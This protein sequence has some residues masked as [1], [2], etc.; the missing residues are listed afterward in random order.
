M[1]LSDLPQDIQDELRK[2]R[3]ELYKTW[4]TNNSYHI[5]FTNLEGTRYFKADRIST[6]YSDLN[7]NYMPFGGGSYWK[8]SY[9]KILWN[10]Q[11][12]PMN[13]G[14][15]YFWVAS[16]SKYSTSKNGTEIPDKLAQKSEVIEL[17][18]K[19]GNLIIE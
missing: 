6:P 9:G 14:Y 12:L 3:A 5:L 7:G 2:K 17:A 18:K 19:I 1:T 10:R 13:C 4:K 11:K 8:I 15:D 16:S